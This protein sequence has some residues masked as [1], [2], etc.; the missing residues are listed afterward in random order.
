MVKKLLVVLFLIT[1]FVSCSDNSFNKNTAVG[2]DNIKVTEPVLYCDSAILADYSTGSIIY[3]KNSDQIIPPAS[4][5]KLV[6]SYIVF[7]EIEKGNVSLDDYVNVSSNSD[8]RN[9]PPRS[10]LMF[11]E[12][13]QKVTLRECLSGLAIP[14]GNDAAVAVAEYISGDVESFIERMNTEMDKLGLEKT[15]FADTSGYSENNQTTAKEFLEFCIKYIDSFPGAATEFHSTESFAY[16]LPENYGSNSGSVHGTIVQNNHNMLIGRV[17]GVD[18]LK[19]G[20]IDESGFN[21]A[22]SAEKDG[23]KLV[24]VIMGSRADNPSESRI[25]GSF[26]ASVLLTYGFSSF[27]TVEVKPELPSPLRVWK[28]KEK[29]TVIQIPETIKVTVPV[30]KLDNIMY[31]FKFDEP[32]IAPLMQGDSA[33]SLDIYSDRDIYSSIPLEIATDVERGGVFRVLTDNI[34]LFIRYRLFRG[35]K[36]TVQ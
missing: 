25:R 21:V 12:E 24:G 27:R 2:I 13:G 29:Y 16:P 1:V 8:F 10:S 7:K 34:G 26:D 22:L 32:L 9:Q 33:G 31:S 20:Y 18:G 35:N 30:R 23:M 15:R 19:T 36:K 4:M 28:G 6:V 11:L 14:S 3:E 17:D 5:T